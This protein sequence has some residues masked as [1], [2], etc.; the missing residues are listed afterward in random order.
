MKSLIYT[1]I[2]IITPLIYIAQIPNSGFESWTQVGQYL[3]P[4]SWTTMNS[5][6]NPLGIYTAEKG[7]PGSPGSSYLKLTSKTVGTS[8]VNGIAICG[9]MNPINFQISPGFAYVDQPAAFTGKWQHMIYGTSQGSVTAVL[10]RWDVTNNSRVIVA[11]ANKVLTGM[12]MS[13]ANFNVPFVYSDGL[14]PDSCYILL[15]ASGNQPTDQD[16][17]W[18]DN[19][20]FSGNVATLNEDSFLG[21]ELFP[22]PTSEILNVN[23]IDLKGNEGLI[24]IYDIQGDLVFENSI[25]VNNGIID[26]K[27]QTQNWKKGFYFLQ[28]QLEQKKY[29]YTFNI[30]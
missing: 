14:A 8:V 29:A 1:L 17:L 21:I 9:S 20:S 25:K 6:T 2:A 18:V 24:E 26:Y 22:N 16:Y 13:W 4:D 30:E 27:I 5:T 3:E 23:G 28:I 7:T 10:T 11:T 15:K 19:L 12:A